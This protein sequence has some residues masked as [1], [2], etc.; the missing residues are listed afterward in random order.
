[1]PPTISSTKKALR[2]RV[3][4]AIDP[5][6][7]TA[8]A[9]GGSATT[10]TTTNPVIINQPTTP[11]FYLGAELSTVGGTGTGQTRR[12][13][14]FAVAAGVATFTVDSWTA[15]DST[16]EFEIHR[17]FRKAQY[18]YAIDAAI[19]A[20][21][22]SIFTDTQN[23]SLAI[24][25]GT[26]TTG[27]AGAWRHEYPMPSGFNHLWGVD[28]LAKPPLATNGI[29]TMDTWRALGDA[30]A[31]TRLWQGF[32][33]FQ[34]T[35]LGY[36]AVY[37]SKVAS[38]TDNLSID[39][40]ANS[41][42]IPSGT[43]VTDGGSATVDGSTIPTR[44][45]LQVFTWNPPPI[46]ARDTQYHLVLKRSGAVSATNYWR[47][48]EDDDNSYSDGTAGTYDAT[49]YTAVSGSDFIF[50]VSADHHFWVELAPANWEYRPL[51]TDQLYIARLPYEGTPLRLRGG[52]A[53]ARPTAETT[54]LDVRPE[55]VEAFVIAYLKA[56]QAGDA[57]PDN[58]MAGSQL[59]MQRMGLL[60]LPHR[61]LPANSI[62][63]F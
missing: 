61:R 41:A 45:R 19:D 39:I 51:T 5:D 53:I 56:G 36:V 29:G 59:W 31:R 8:T 21:A 52:A 44:P 47:L 35:L 38:P 13:N 17:R 24:E 20:M 25:R 28:Y 62:R 50:S 34:D 3:A 33:V 40:M 10:L 4:Q 49:T 48:G 57:S 15:V 60:P 55:W 11:S 27:I 43:L 46:L 14:T 32:K 2:Q 54:T 1:M 7:V 42:G 6:F 30:T 58:L 18:D 16:T 37:L 22:D 23:I 12:I 9:T 63:I 26:G